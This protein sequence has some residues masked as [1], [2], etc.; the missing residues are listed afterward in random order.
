MAE[1]CGTAKVDGA[2]LTWCEID[3]KQETLRLWLRDPEGRPWGTFDRLSEALEADGK[4][5]GLA[6]NAGMYHQDRA[7]VGHYVEEGKNLMRVITSE[8]PGNFGLLPNGVFCLK[9]STAS[10]VESRAFAKSGVQC[11]F[12]TQSGPM[13]VIDGALHPRFLVDSNSYKRRNGVGTKQDGA[14]VILAITD[15]PMTFHQF[16]R[17]F[18]DQAKTPNALFLDGSVSRLYAPNL[19]RHD[20][21]H[22]MGPI[23]GTVVPNG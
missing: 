3:L 2:R 13:L 18:R 22:P 10:V 9:G 4:T 19:K 14:K 20:L 6:M 15:D 8:G 23:L 16:A 12:A 17:F 5:L 11:E 7:P 21:G 1:T